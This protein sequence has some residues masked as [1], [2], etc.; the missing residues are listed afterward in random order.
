MK[1]KE[2]FIIFLTVFIDLVGFGIIIPLH[3]YLATEFGADE[4]SIGLLVAIYS[5][6]QFLCSPFWGQLSDRIGRRPV[7]LI[8]L[9]GVGLSHLAFGLAGEFYM[10]VIARAFAGFF[11]ANISTAMAYMADRTD[12][13]NRSKAMGM[14]GAAFGLGF[15]IGPFLGYFFIQIGNQLGTEAPFGNSFAAIMAAVICLLNFAF[16]YFY[17]SESLTIKPQAEEKKLS[18]RFKNLKKYF[19]V[20]VVSSLLLIF[21]CYSIAMACMEIPLFLYVKDKFGWGVGVASLG[22]AYMGLLQV[23]VQGYFVRKYIGKIGESKMLMIGLITA[24]IGFTGIGMANSLTVLAIVVTVLGFGIGVISP[25]VNG[26]ISLLAKDSE[27]GEALG[28]SQSLSALGRIIGPIIGGWL[29]RDYGPSSP[30]FFGGLIVF[31]GI[32]LALKSYKQMPVAA[33]KVG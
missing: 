20:P 2:Q 9:L 16:A 7:I 29:Y 32:L 11:G 1:N 3:P 19:S 26:M 22:F 8:S 13:A 24:G 12:R 33:K 6:M 30:F 15:T 18:S 21:T 27:Q 17:L 5:F 28:V 10:L 25:S 31:I 23:F 4:L 14:I